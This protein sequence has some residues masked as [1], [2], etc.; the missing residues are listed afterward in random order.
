MSPEERVDKEKRQLL[1]ETAQ[2][3]LSQF[4]DAPPGGVQF[5]IVAQVIDRRGRVLKQETLADVL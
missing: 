4:R 2:H 1:R 5:D 3:Y